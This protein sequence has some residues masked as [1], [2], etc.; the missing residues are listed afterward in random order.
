MTSIDEQ[1]DKMPEA[2]RERFEKLLIDV[3]YSRHWCRQHGIDYVN[4]DIDKA[5]EE[6]YKEL[7]K[8]KY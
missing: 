8:K 6:L 3:L 7:L 1:I 5:R 4:P 2:E